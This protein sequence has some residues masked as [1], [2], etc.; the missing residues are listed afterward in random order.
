[1]QEDQ[2]RESES[3]EHQEWGISIVELKPDG[4]ITPRYRLDSILRVLY[5]TPPIP[6]IQPES[7]KL[8][9]LIA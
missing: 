8:L 2:T 9:A 4:S 7:S 5:I 3:F 1:M 6:S